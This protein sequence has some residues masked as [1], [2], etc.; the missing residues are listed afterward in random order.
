MGKL[1]LLI[2][3][4]MS[5]NDKKLTK[6]QQSALNTMKYQKLLKKGATYVRAQ[7]FK[8]AFITYKEALNYEAEDPDVYYNLVV[9]G[10]V[11]KKVN[12][13]YFYALA[14]ATAFKQGGADFKK[15][16][17]YVKKFIKLVPKTARLTIKSQPKGVKIYINKAFFGF[18]NTPELTLPVGKYSLEFTKPDFISQKKEI[19]LDEGATKNID[20][21]LQ[22]II[23]HGY[24]QLTTV[25]AKGVNVTVDGKSYGKSPVGK[26]KLETG[27]D[28]LI[29]LKMKGYDLWKRYIQVTKD[30]TV[31]VRAKLYKPVPE[32]PDEW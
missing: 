22:P 8:R 1:F 28:H 17:S 6:V 10:E 21:Q 19:N 12:E 13:V 11:L 4:S 23:Y 27:K 16:N 15:I 14:Y 5:A 3:L 29:Q 32:E 25:P 9:V 26:I 7:N 20:I 18:N 24:L 30:K 31:E 2:L